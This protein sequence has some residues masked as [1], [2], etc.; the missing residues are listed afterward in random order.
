MWNIFST[1]CSLM[2]FFPLSEA[3]CGLKCNSVQHTLLES[4]KGL[5]SMFSIMWK[6]Y[7]GGGSSKIILYKLINYFF[8]HA[9]MG[10][11][12][13]ITS[14]KK[15]LSLLTGPVVPAVPLCPW[16]CTRQLYFI[17]LTSQIAKARNQHVEAVF[18]G[19]KFKA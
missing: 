5:E 16:F 3:N 6:L 13:I 8:S 18:L 1:G 15:V 9:V 12:L 11:T 17:Q 2:F 4:W 19:I 7:C 10:M 14:C